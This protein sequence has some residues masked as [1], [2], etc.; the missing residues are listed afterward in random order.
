MLLR[1]RRSLG[2]ASAS[3][4][5]DEGLSLL[6]QQSHRSTRTDGRSW[7]VLPDLNIR[8]CG[9]EFSREY[10]ILTNTSGGAQKR[11]QLCIVL[12]VCVEVDF[13][14]VLK[15]LLQKCTKNI[16]SSFSL[17]LEEWQ[18]QF[19]ELSGIQTGHTFLR[20]LFSTQVLQMNVTNLNTLYEERF[21]WY[22]HNSGSQFPQNYWSCFWITME[23]ELCGRFRFD[24]ADSCYTSTFEVKNFASYLKNWKLWKSRH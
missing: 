24:V 8:C 6:P 9:A 7:Q 1:V 22:H 4:R 12:Q 3:E 16:I 19:L 18:I 20:I 10:Q 2:D 13:L 14:F 21:P 23:I 11:G 15:K 17:R 5:H